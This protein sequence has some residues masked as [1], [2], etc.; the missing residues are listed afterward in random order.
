MPFGCRIL[1]IFMDCINGIHTLAYESIKEI[2]DFLLSKTSQ[3]YRYKV[4]VDFLKSYK[5]YDI[6]KR[7][8]LFSEPFFQKLPKLVSNPSVDPFS[9]IS[10][11]TSLWI[12]Y[13]IALSYVLYTQRFIFFYFAV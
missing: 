13:H 4:I 11:W 3:R 12:V 9:I 6:I 8:W 10:V 7:Q 1:N 5:V 2:F